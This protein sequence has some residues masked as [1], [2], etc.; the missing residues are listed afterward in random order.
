M[1]RIHSL[2]IK[3][4]RG[5]KNFSH[6]FGSSNLNCLIGRGDSGKS[7]ILDAIYVGLS[8]NWNEIFHDGDFHNGDHT[9]PIEIEITLTNVPQDLVLD[10]KF[11]EYKKGYNP[12]TGQIFEDIDDDEPTESA[13]TIKLEVTG[14]LEPKWF[15]VADRQAEPKS[16]SHT[17]RKKLN[18]LFVSDSVDKHFLWSKWN[19]LYNLLRQDS[20]T[21]GGDAN[22]VL[23]ILREAKQKID[24]CEPEQFAATMQKVI[25]VS[26]KFGIDL[27]NAS[28][29]IDFKDIVVKDGRFSLHDESIPFRLKGKGSKRLISMAI[30]TALSKAGGI[31]L[32]DELEQSLEP[33]RITHAAATLLKETDAQVFITTHSKD[34]LVELKTENL[35]L[36][37]QSNSSLTTFSNSLQGLLRAHADTF[38]AKRVIV[39]EGSTEIGI[40]RALNKYRQAKGLD[41]FAV[42]AVAYT[43]GGGDSMIDYCRGFV[44]SEF[45]TAL[46]CDSDKASINEKKVELINIGVSIFDWETGFALEHAVAKYLPYEGVKKMLILAK[47]SKSKKEELAVDDAR[48]AIWNSVKSKFTGECPLKYLTTTDS[49]E[50]RTAIGKAAQSKSNPWFKTIR[51]GELLGDIIFNH[52]EEIKADPLG[53]QLQSLLDWIDADG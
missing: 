2:K 48:L 26:K 10:R 47:D 11:A 43:K 40:C 24:T 9:Q 39:C 22:I 32:I 53:K 35:L 45:P 29:K 52:F 36:V 16:I 50:L 28:T 13:L 44:Q 23:D 3:N 5:I 25:E 7:T 12:A 30:Q 31:I 6:T 38:F 46:F 18:V 21:D 19:P 1:A 41:S 51:D 8:P 34:V 14:D 20:G 17:D 49:E 42:K 27:P 33:D 15:V 4:F 37:R